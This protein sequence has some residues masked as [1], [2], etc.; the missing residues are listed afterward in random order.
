MN[1]IVNQR[2]SSDY[3]LPSQNN[4]PLHHN[5]NPKHR[6]S[7]AAAD[8][9]HKESQI[10]LVKKRISALCVREQKYT[11]KTVNSDL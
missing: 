4:S 10:E 11:H 8:L 1:K 2:Y 9:L 5:L 6:K 7:H 3:Q